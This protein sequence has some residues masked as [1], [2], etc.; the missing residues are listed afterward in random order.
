MYR[1]KQ[2]T[3]QLTSFNFVFSLVLCVLSCHI[4]YIFL[5]L[6]LL[7]ASQQTETWFALRAHSEGAH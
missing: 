2:K 3:A 4:L 5:V 1:E 6:V 7:L